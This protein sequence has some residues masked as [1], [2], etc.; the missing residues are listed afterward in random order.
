M[1]SVAIAAALYNLN[2]SFDRAAISFEVA[3]PAC[4]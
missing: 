2:A 3:R 4:T 1:V